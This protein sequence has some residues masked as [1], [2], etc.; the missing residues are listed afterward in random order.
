MK[1]NDQSSQQG[2]TE[3]LSDR[4]LKKTI[5]V[6]E[7]DWNSQKYYECLLSSEYDIY[8]ASTGGSAFSMLEEFGFDL[9]LMDIM[10]IGDEDGLSLT[11]RLRSNPKYARLPIIAISAYAF[12]ED[13]AKAL[14]AGCNDFLAKPVRK[15]DLLKAINTYVK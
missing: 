14:K 13:R 15:D 4:V 2:S 8:T 1:D 9:V 3:K 12:P 5:L 11:R 10:I 7:D 6:V